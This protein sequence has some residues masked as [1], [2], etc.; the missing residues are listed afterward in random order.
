[1]QMSGLRRA[2]RRARP[3]CFG[4][5]DDCAHVLVG[6]RRLLRDPAA[7]R[8]ADQY[9]LRGEVVHDL[10][11]APPLESGMARKR[12][13]SAVARRSEGFRLGGFHADQN[14]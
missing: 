7:R 8:A 14:E 12:T 4:R 3:A 5:R 9:A 6:A 10:A 1:M 13:A 2:T 11:S